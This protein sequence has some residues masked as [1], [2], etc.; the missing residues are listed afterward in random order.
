MATDTESPAVMTFFF[1]NIP[2][3]NAM[4]SI[5]A[6]ANKLQFLQANWAFS[7][8]DGIAFQIAGHQINKEENTRSAIIR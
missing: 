6:M 5:A 4:K 3:T 7:I 8:I 1:G 2:T